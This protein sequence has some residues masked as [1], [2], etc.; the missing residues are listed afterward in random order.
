MRQLAGDASASVLLSMGSTGAE[1]SFNSL[2]TEIMRSR[3]AHRLPHRSGMG[4]MMIWFLVLLHIAFVG[5]LLVA[6]L[7]YR[8]KALARREAPQKV[9]CVYEFALPTIPMAGIPKNAP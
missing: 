3:D 2:R 8:P 7:R 4:S 5:M 6:W 9:H 1:M